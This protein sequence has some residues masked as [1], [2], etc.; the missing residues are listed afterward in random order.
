MAKKVWDAEELRDEMRA[1]VLRFPGCHRLVVDV[2]GLGD[3]MPVLLDKPWINPDDPETEYP[4]IVLADNMMPEGGALPLLV[5]FIASNKLNNAMVNTLRYHLEQKLIR[6]PLHSA[7]F[8]NSAVLDEETGLSKR[9][10]AIQHFA[11]FAETDALQIELGNLIAYIGV[12]GAIRYDVQQFGQHKDRFSALA[13]AL[14]QAS[15]IEEDARAG[16]DE[17]NGV[18]WGITRKM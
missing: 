18:C 15:L 8:D 7:E 10:A 6:L 2:N 3:C 1:L 4:P 13:M 5:P 14:Y 12:S 11:I 16:Y 9:E 17:D